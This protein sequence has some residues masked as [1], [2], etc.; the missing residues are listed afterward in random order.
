MTALEEQTV[1]RYRRQPEIYYEEM[2]DISAATYDEYLR[3]QEEFKNIPFESKSVVR[4]KV[5]TDFIARAE[6]YLVTLILDDQ[7]IAQNEEDETEY[8]RR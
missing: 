8:V 7:L 6:Q 2:V 4:N 1:A 3:R 5:Y